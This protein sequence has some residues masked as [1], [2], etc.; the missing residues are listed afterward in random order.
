MLDTSE[1]IV[2]QLNTKV[3]QTDMLPYLGIY[4]FMI[5]LF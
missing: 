3:L 2:A 1:L 4:F 5:A